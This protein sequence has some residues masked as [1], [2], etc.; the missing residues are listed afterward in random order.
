MVESLNINNGP[1]VATSQDDIGPCKHHWIIE[2]P[3]GPTSEGTC[4]N[5]GDERQFSN[6]SVDGIYPSRRFG[7]GVDL[8][9]TQGGEYYHE[10]GANPRESGRVAKSILTKNGTIGGRR[11]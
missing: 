11:F 6:S 4:K 5:C 3:S 2:T 7:D 10:T 9:Q 8:T 1:E